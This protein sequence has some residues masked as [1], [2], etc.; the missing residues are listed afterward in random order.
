MT[1]EPEDLSAK[2]SPIPTGRVETNRGDPPQSQFHEAQLLGALVAGVIS[3]LMA[4]DHLLA[5]RAR[6]HNEQVL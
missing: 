6:R 5:N 3:L 1:F 2:L 4:L